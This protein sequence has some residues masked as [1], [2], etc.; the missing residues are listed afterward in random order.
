MSE[1]TQCDWCGNRVPLDMLSPDREDWIE[2]SWG[3]GITM[4]YCTA[5]CAVAGIEKT[6]DEEAALLMSAMDEEGKG[7]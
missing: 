5:A 1:W 2:V 6:R 3:S 7:D 4:D